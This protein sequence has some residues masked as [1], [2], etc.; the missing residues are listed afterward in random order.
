MAHEVRASIA[1]EIIGSYLHLARPAL[2]RMIP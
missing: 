2:F 1:Q